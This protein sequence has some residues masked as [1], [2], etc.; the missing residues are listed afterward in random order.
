MFKH[1]R[2]PFFSASGQPGPILYLDTTYNLLANSVAQI[3]N[4]HLAPGLYGGDDMG[5]QTTP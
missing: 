1:P 2:P 3:R 5:P 4:A